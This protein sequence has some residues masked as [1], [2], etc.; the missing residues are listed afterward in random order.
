MQ[1]V[2]VCAT[3]ASAQSAK[4][5]HVDEE[6]TRWNGNVLPDVDFVD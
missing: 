4:W 1:S 3:M 2:A 6:D 5:L